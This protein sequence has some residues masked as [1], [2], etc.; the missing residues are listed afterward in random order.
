MRMAQFKEGGRRMLMYELIV[1]WETGEKDTCLYD[2]ENEA[3][4]AASNYKFAFGNQIA[5]TGI[6]PKFVDD[7]FRIGDLREWLYAIA[8]NNEDLCD[9]IGDII[10]RLPRF[11]QYVR[12]MEAADYQDKRIG[13]CITIKCDDPT[14]L[15]EIIEKWKRGEYETNN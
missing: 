8:L 6:R 1:I 15:K 12:D 13:S 3:E 11:K 5:W 14:K 2:T 10:A 9:C 4:K 7:Y